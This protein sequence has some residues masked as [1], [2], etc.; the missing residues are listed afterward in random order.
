METGD[1]QAALATYGRLAALGDDPG[2]ARAL[3]HGVLEGIAQ[4]N[5]EMG[6]ILGEAGD[7]DAAAGR[8][9]LALSMRAELLFERPDDLPRTLA[10]AESIVGVTWVHYARRENFDALAASR[11]GAALLRPLV[12]AGSLPLEWQLWFVWMVGMTGKIQLDEGN[13][14]AAVEA[15]GESI[16]LQQGLIEAYPDNTPMRTALARDLATVASAH[17]AMGDTGPAVTA[18]RAGVEMLT[19]LVTDDPGDLRSAALLAQMLMDLG[20]LLADT[21]QA[22][23]GLDVYRMSR[24]VH[25]A[26]LQA[27]PDDRGWHHRLALVY[28]RLASHGEEPRS[29][30]QG[31]I[32]IFSA[33]LDEGYLAADAEP[34]LDAARRNLA[35]AIAAEEGR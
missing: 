10:L 24:A 27:Y 14:A 30:W 23:D 7:M 12:E 22:E 32:D 31:V 9:R 11:S 19:R 25:E 15:F 29:N 8:Q 5:H 3:D 35:D 13:A 1:A 18:Y 2:W 28:W 17:V 6:R 20:D 26:I 4:A 21:G 16:L 33:L 34:W